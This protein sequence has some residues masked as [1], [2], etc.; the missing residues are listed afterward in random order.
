MIRVLFF[1]VGGVLLSNGWDRRA[2]AQAVVRFG[3]DGAEFAERH[4][5]VAA[6]FETGAMSLEEYLDRTVF[7][8]SRDFTPAAFAAFM[9][10]RSRPR[11]A[12]LRLV[13]SLAGTGRHLLATLNNESRELNA[14]RIERFGLRDLFSV[15]CSS[16]YLGVR[17]PEERIYRMAVE[18]VAADPGE[19]LFVDDRLLNLECAERLGMRTVHH[20]GAAR[21]RAALT[22]AG[23]EVPAAGGTG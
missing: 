5:L 3:L 1:D 18:L 12:V 13:A 22:A 4:A 2:R 17:K 20:R 9:R 8:R 11:P 16:C 19:C 23:V 14:Y 10:S 21:L 6:A 7:H 15:F